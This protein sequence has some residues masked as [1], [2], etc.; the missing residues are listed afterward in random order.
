MRSVHFGFGAD[1]SAGESPSVGLN[2]RGNVL[3]VYESGNGEKC[4]RVGR[5]SLA[6]IEWKGS[7]PAGSGVT[8]RVALNNH[9]IAVEVH[10][11]P[12]HKVLYCRAGRL[13]V[14]RDDEVAWPHARSYAEGANRTRPALGLN[15]AGIVVEEHEVHEGGKQWLYHAVG[16]VKEETGGE[17]YVEWSRQRVR[18]AEAA[19]PAV[20]INNH[21]I[22]VEVHRYPYGNRDRRLFYSVGRVNE[23]KTAIELE[24]RQQI[25]VNRVGVNGYY[26]SVAVTDDDLVIVVLR[27][28][29]RIEVIELL[30]EISP[31]R[32]S[33][34]WHRWWYYD[35]G[36]R[37]AVA[38]AGTMAVEVHQHEKSSD[39]RFSTSIITDRASW[40]QRRLP[41]LGPKRI[42]D[43]VLPASHDAGSY[44]DNLNRWVR[45]QTLSIYEQ[46]RYG[47]RY[48]DLRPKWSGTVSQGEWMIHHGGYTGPSVQTVLNDVSAFAG[49]APPEESKELMIL[50]LSHFERTNARNYVKLVDQINRTIGQWLVRSK[51]HNKRLADLTLN[52]YVQGGPAILLV[53]DHEFASTIPRPGFWTF[54]NWN[55]GDAGHLSVF[56]V[57][58]RTED[59][60][61]MRRQQLRER[62][63]RFAGLMENGELPCDLFLLSWTLT[64]V[65]EFPW[66]P[67]PPSVRQL[68]RRA[69]PHLGHEIR[70]L[71]EQRPPG[72]PNAHGKI[73][74][75]LYVDFVQSARVTDVALFQNGERTVAA[76]TPKPRRTSKAAA[77]KS[78]AVAPQPKRKR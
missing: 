75:L 68:A 64:P 5:L 49:A 23:A 73:I 9:D 28:R 41:T 59:Y 29:T 60:E 16:Q 65:S 1:F 12:E 22:V 3:A 33:I 52:E 50:K 15:D 24:P 46:L 61:T 37:P 44:T 40:M 7:K 39:L 67:P 4:Y 74:N 20:A 27:N 72:W 45:T 55:A 25:V 71:H 13:G 78:K 18:G 57:W 26:P 17:L 58:S 30:G 8:P 10:R 2:R 11:N 51:P 47:I 54:R 6:T 43:L 63:P 69:N 76:D 32:K 21:G 70:S 14:A 35:D 19:M 66:I 56:D 31:D 38:A 77:P 42:R 62:F 53:V 36:T 48:F 34:I